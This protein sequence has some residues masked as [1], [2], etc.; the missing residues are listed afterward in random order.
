MPL[1]GLRM[2]YMKKEKTKWGGQRE[3]EEESS[4]GGRGRR[5]GSVWGR[6][7]QRILESQPLD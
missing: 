3:A 1:I 2:T 7:E 4:K 6:G 5:V